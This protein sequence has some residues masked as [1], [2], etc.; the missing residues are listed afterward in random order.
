MTTAAIYTRMSMD[1]D[2][3]AVG[4]DVQKEECQALADKLGLHRR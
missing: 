3:K 2:G 1:R 4:V